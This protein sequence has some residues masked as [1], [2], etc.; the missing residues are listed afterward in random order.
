MSFLFCNKQINNEQK[1]NGTVFIKK[2]QSLESE[3]PTNCD[4]FIE[5]INIPSSISGNKNLMDGEIFD[6]CIPFLSEIQFSNDSKAGLSLG[7]IDNLPM[8]YLNGKLIYSYN[9]NSPDHIFYYEKE[10]FFEIDSN[11]IKKNNILIVRIVPIFRRENGM[12]M[13]GGNIRLSNI[14]N[15]IQWSTSYKIYN[16]GKVVL[17]FGA[18][19]LYFTLF[20]ATLFCSI[21]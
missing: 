2:V 18:S 21:N 6:Y 7:Y 20:Y 11:L 15:L 16:F 9:P 10:L 4:T 5:K 3:I 13:Y 17:Y 8:A 19:L 1:L 12:G 14:N